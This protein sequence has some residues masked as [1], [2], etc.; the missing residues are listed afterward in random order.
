MGI[1]DSKIERIAD[2]AQP[3]SRTDMARAAAR[4]AVA[5]INHDLFVRGTIAVLVCPFDLTRKSGVE[6]LIRAVGPLVQEHR[7]LRV[8]LLGDSV[9][10]SRIYDQL[11]FNGCIT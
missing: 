4:N 5:D 10:R 11:R 3:I 9:E 8:W 7:A 6:F 2:S 1:Q